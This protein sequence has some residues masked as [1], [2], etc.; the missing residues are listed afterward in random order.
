M[1][2]LPFNLFKTEL[3]ES[4]LVSDTILPIPLPD[5]QKLCGDDCEGC[6][7]PCGDEGGDGND[8]TRLVISYG[9]NSEIV[10]VIGC[11][12]GYPVVER[13]Q[14]GT[15][16]IDFPVGACVYFTWTIENFTDMTH[17]IMAACGYPCPAV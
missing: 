4:F 11:S 10:K 12:G 1:A 14:E 6:F 3:V 5:A 13:A 7:D 2:F 17:Q 15:T 8:H 16:A 9:S